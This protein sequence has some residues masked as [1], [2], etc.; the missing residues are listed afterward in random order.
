MKRLTLRQNWRDGVL[1]QTEQRRLGKLQHPIS[2][3]DA[4]RHTKA[5]QQAPQ[6]QLLD[7]REK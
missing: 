7:G 1:R 6:M 4:L 3:S 5:R 2:M